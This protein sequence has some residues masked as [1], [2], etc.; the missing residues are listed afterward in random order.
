MGDMAF[1]CGVKTDNL[2]LILSDRPRMTTEMQCH[3]SFAQ[4]HMWLYL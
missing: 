1:F 2:G 4:R 3:G